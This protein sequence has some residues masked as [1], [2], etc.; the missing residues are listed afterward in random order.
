[1]RGVHEGRAEM[2]VVVGR[3][4]KGWRVGYEQAA[5]TTSTLVAASGQYAAGTATEW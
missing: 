3:C 1:M 4:R 2:T 5:A